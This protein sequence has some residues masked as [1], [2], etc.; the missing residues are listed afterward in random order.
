MRERGGG[1]NEGMN[2]RNS[3]V[4]VSHAHH[5]VNLLHTFGN[6]WGEILR[7][8]KL[9]HVINNI[10]LKLS[11]PQLTIPLTLT[12]T[13]V[14]GLSFRSSLM[15][16]FLLSKSRTSSWYI[17]RYEARTRYCS[18][19]VRAMWVKMCSNE[20]G[21]TPLSSGQSGFPSIVYVLPVPVCPYANMVPNERVQRTV[22]ERTIG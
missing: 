19:W 3:S 5:L 16:C 13:P 20:F 4:S 14:S 6:K 22:S 17:S 12:Y 8:V 21:M 15:P 7:S 18:S 1:G 10:S 9:T 2:S 11:S